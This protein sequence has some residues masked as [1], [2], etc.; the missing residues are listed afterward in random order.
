MTASQ[1]GL[2]LRVE[3]SNWGASRRSVLSSIGAVAGIGL[4]SV[5]GQTDGRWTIGDRGSVRR[6]DGSRPVER[7]RQRYGV[8]VR[9][10][11]FAHDRCSSESFTLCLRQRAGQRR[12][13]YRERRYFPIWRAGD[14]GRQHHTDRTAGNPVRCVTDGNGQGP[15]TVESSRTRCR[16]GHTTFASRAT[17]P[18]PTSSSTPRDR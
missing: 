12:G 18:S 16:H 10:C 7:E 5:T 4:F 2:V 11:Q 17:S 3:P 8:V 6:H 15:R 14:D 13:R 9:Q 1:M